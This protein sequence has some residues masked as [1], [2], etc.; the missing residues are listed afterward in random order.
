MPQ[1]PP[2]HKNPFRRTRN[3]HAQETA[4][5]YVEA[6]YQILCEQDTCRAKDL[7]LVFAVSHVTVHR[8]VARLQREGLLETA[9]YQPITLTAKGKRLAK[10]ARQRHDI[11]YRFLLSIGVTPEVAANDAEG[12]EHHVSQ[13][14]L[15]RFEQAI[16]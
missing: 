14:T 2:L 7:A 9:P 4:E 16:E 6:V 1:T 8:I 10:K 12:I 15:D 11:V 3:D 13:Q 5:D